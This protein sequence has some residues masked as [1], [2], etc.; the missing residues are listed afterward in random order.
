MTTARYFDFKISRNKL[1]YQGTTVGDFLNCWY[2]PREVVNYMWQFEVSDSKIFAYAKKGKDI[3]DLVSDLGYFPEKLRDRM[4]AYGL[5]PTWD[6]WH[7]LE[8]D[9]NRNSLPV[10]TVEAD[11]ES[12]TDRQVRK[13]VRKHGPQNLKIYFELDSTLDRATD[14]ETREH[15]GYSTEERRQEINKV[16]RIAA[17][18]MTGMEFEDAFETVEYGY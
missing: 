13:F 2:T 8:S 14:P 12:M 1:L 18:E 4:T 3:C 5:T 6:A 10:C 11:V 17:Y 16:W 15:F 7:Q 9:A